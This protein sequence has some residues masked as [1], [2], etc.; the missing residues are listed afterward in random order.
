MVESAMKLLATRGLQ[1]TSFT[2]VLEDSGAPR[3]S[4]YH[5]FPEGKDQL[6]AAALDLASG[7]ALALMESRAGAPAAELSAL[8]L[9]LWRQVLTR[10]H[11]QAGCSVLAVTVATDSQALRSQTADIFRTW[12]SSLAR[13][14]EQGGLLQRDAAAFAATLIAASEGAVVLSRSE[15]NLEPFELVAE[16]LL[17]QV[18]ALESASSKAKTT[19]KKPKKR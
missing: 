7:R 13:L 5:H 9:E 6:V 4:L 15:Q 8:F 10:S 16:Q 2:E 17:T 12:R 19:Q 1:A 11:F 3:G 14:L 18:K